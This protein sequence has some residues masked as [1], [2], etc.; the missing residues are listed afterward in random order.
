MLKTQEAKKT[1]LCSN[2]LTSNMHF[3]KKSKRKNYAT[4]ILLNASRFRNKATNCV[5]MYFIVESKY[6]TLYV[7]DPAFVGQLMI[8]FET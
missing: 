8:Y 1:L 6:N 2:D 7:I 4:I 3:F 5:I